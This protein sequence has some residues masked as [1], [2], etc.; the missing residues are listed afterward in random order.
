MCKRQCWLDEWKLMWRFDQ[1]Q[2]LIRFTYTHFSF[3]WISPFICVLFIRF[4]VVVVIIFFSFKFVKLNGEFFGKN[5]NKMIWNKINKYDCTNRDNEKWRKKKRQILLHY[6]CAMHRDHYRDQIFIVQ[7]KQLNKR[8]AQHL[9]NAID[10]IQF[11]S[12]F[13]KLPQ[14]K[15]I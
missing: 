3:T 2:M 9:R 1:R 4:N 6:L 11:H 13:N 5:R 12:V 10:P 15:N 14:K 8:R 7:N